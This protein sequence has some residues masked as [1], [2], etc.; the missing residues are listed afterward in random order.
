MD[1]IDGDTNFDD[2]YEYGSDV[3]DTY[4]YIFNESEDEDG[5]SNDDQNEAA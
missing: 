4:D 1:P 3:E 5:Y 2:E